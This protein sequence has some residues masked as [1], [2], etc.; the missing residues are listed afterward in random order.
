MA[1]HL[2]SIEEAENDLL[3]CATRLAE[4]VR[5]AEGHAEALKTIVPFYLQRREV[6]L[7]AQLADTISDPFTRDKLLMSVA[8]K[9]AE[10]DDD[11]YAFQLTEAIEDVGLQG[12]ALEKIAIRQ[13][14]KGDIEKAYEIAERLDHPDNVYIE[15]AVHFAGEG[16]FQRADEALDSITFPT[17]KAFALQII[18]SALLEKHR[19]KDAVE[20]L[21]RALSAAEEIDFD[22]DE[23]RVLTEIG[24]LFVQAKRRDRAIETF[25]KARQ[26]AEKMDSVHREYLLSAISLGFFHAGSLNLADRALDLIQDK[27]QISSTLV[28]FAVGFWERDEKSEAF[29][30]LEEAYQILKSQS[31]KETRDSRAKFQLLRT[32]A[33]QFAG[34]E[35]YE[36]A[37][38][39]AQE[40]V[41]EAEQTAALS[42]I[43]RLAA[44]RGKDDWADQAIK[45]I[46]EDADRTF[47]Y[48]N[49]ADAK[50]SLN[51]KEKAHDFL[52]EAASLAESIP[53][54]PSRCEAY[55]ELIRR[56]SE[57]GKNDRAREVF[58]ENLATIA[59]IRDESLRAIALANLS[60][61]AEKC[62]FTLTNEEK[63]LLRTTIR[64]AGW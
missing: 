54:L 56:F 39:T 34:F 1:E 23:I 29:E 58:G 17:A 45:A 15:L 37:I 47:A 8:E 27:T 32:I 52:D 51:T 38:E 10:I 50:D 63:E 26:I 25:D 49:L 22:T 60:E 44:L 55:N 33:V 21:E 62:G 9:C 11:D 7:A 13:I 36:R 61:V 6:D 18:A 12:E 42:Q 48:L 57:R 53:Q 19:E 4:N 28:G 2:I 35:K 3:A 16:N 20:M 14:L 59:Q 31:E 24:N 30:A 5:S 41:D 43:A 40:I 46:S 64:Q